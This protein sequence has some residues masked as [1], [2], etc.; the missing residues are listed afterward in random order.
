[1]KLYFATGTC[2]LSPHIALLEAGLQFEAER[3]D[4]R[5]K[6]TAGG[7][8]Y[9]AVN[10]KGYVPALQL[11]DGTV[12]TEGPAIVQYIAD[13]VPA[14]NLMAP[15]GTMERY[16][17]IEWLTFINSEIHKTFS[18]LFNPA[19]PEATRENQRQLLARRFD[20]VEKTLADRTFLTGS[21][22]TVADGYLFTVLNW[23]AP[24]KIDMTP[25][26]N[27][28]AFQSRVAARPCARAAMI[29]EG[30]IKE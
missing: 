11:D 15:A 14:K 2:A 6:T 20:F 13:Q 21:T 27:L 29:A 10:P 16:K 23:A 17:Q 12:L 18:T 26:P 30:L 1:M 22:Y 8:D 7:G 3:V 5:A 28:L 24:C 9:L 4:L 19:T 25:W